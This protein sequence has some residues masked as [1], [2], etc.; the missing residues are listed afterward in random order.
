[1]NYGPLVFLAAFLGLSASWLGFVLKPQMQV[2]Q[3]QQTN[4]VPAFATYPVAR[5][6]LAREGIEVYRANGCAYC[7]SQQVLQ[8]GT[9]CDVVLGQAG[10]NQPSLLA[11]LAGLKPGASEAALTEMLGKLPTAV[12]HGLTKQE[13]DDAVKAIN[14]T[15]AKAQVWVTPT[16]PDLARGWGRRRTVAQDFLYD[17]PLMLGEQRIGPDL[18]NVGT[19]QPDPNWHLRH[20]YAPKLEVKDSV[21]PPYRYLF[22]KRKIEQHRSPDAL[23]LPAELAPA[24]GY[25]IVPGPDAIALVAYLTSLK[26]DAP[27]FEAPL[28]VA[29]APPPPA[30]GTNVPPGEGSASTNSPGTNSP[31]K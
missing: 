21:M 16:G 9:V 3:L 8:T 18:A 29:M 5:P 17:Y 20:L 1:M 23:A 10:T 26:A 6:G 12:L 11:V 24:R 25:E 14:A 7:H 15:S 27:L 19:R 2:G 28:S 30:A 31:S 4:T 22:Q 13:A